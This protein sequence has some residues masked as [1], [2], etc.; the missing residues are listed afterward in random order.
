VSIS[1]MWDGRLSMDETIATDGIP[2][3]HY[4]GINRAGSET[5]S[6]P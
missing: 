1:R 2:H 3:S 6:F 5:V 4:L